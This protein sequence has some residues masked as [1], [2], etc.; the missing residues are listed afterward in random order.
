MV[1]RTVREARQELDSLIAQR[2]NWID[3]NE[4][5]TALAFMT[6]LQRYDPRI[7]DAEITYTVNLLESL[8][9]GSRRLGRLTYALVVL[10]FILICLTFFLALKMA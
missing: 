3:H 4:G 8:D 2:N 1:P 9:S 10:T 6:E 7:R 5:A